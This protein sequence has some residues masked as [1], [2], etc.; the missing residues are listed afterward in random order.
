MSKTTLA[1]IPVHMF[2]LGQLLFMNP[3][4]APL[5]MLGLVS[6]VRGGT[7]R[8][9]LGFAFLV[10]VAA[11]LVT[12]GKPYYLA[13]A[14]PV[15]L[16]AGATAFEKAFATRRALVGSVLAILALTSI[17]FGLVGLPILRVASIDHGLQVVLGK[18]V[19]P[20]ELTR[21]LHDQFGFRE[22]V[23]VVASVYDSLPSH[24]RERALVLTAN[25][26]QASAVNFFGKSRGLPRAVTGHMTYFLWGVPPGKGE[27]VIAY[28]LPRE[29][30]ESVYAD[31]REVGVVD[32]PLAMPSERNLVVYVAR[33]PRVPLGEA[34]PRF[35]RYQHGR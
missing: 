18:L 6:L 7:E 9:V 26:G 33:S 27:V 19:K 15:L 1:A 35:Q 8:R 29:R 34:W 25:Y 28:G 32:H 3:F 2:L 22:Q 16:A 24:E 10:V 5:W 23:D 12:H 4:T 14:Y 30:V 31:V 17:V 11:L 20:E 13:P 21:E